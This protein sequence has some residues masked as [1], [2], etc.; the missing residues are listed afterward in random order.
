MNHR[1]HLTRKMGINQHFPREPSFWGCDF[2]DRPY[3][4]SIALHT[5]HSTLDLFNIN[6]Y[7]KRQSESF[8]GWA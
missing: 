3:V 6:Q 8:S 4:C 2:E 1:L 7:E 5:T